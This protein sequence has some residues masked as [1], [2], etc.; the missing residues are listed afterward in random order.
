MA[1]IQITSKI[2]FYVHEKLQRKLSVGRGLKFSFF[3]LYEFENLG[4]L[5][6]GYNAVKNTMGLL[7]GAKCSR[8]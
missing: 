8:E 3:E 7:Q 4:F 5:K 1:G 6:K 2:C